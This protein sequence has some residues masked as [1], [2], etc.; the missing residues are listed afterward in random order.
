MRA[1]QLVYLFREVLGI[2][3]RWVEGRRSYVMYAV[4]LITTTLPT[5]QGVVDLGGG[6]GASLVVH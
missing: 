3:L 5:R 1:F 6:S 2:F 4:S